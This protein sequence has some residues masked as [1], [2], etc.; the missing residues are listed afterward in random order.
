M[1]YFCLQFMSQTPNVLWLAGWY[2]TVLN[3]MSGDFIQR[4]ARA[5]SRHAPLHLIHVHALVDAVSVPE[6]TVQK[7]DALTENIFYFNAGKSNYF[8]KYLYFYSYYKAY[9]KI[10][11]HW[12]KLHGKP[13]VVHVHAPDRCG[14][15][16]VWVKRKYKSKLIFTEHWAIYNNVVNDNYKTR[17]LMFKNALKKLLRNAQKAVQVSHS[18][19]ADMETCTR[20]Q[21]PHEKIPNTVNTDLFNLNN[22][23]AENPFRFIHVS[24]M[25]ERKNIKGLLRTF[26]KLQMEYP[27][28]ELVLVGPLSVALKLW[29]QENELLEKIICMGELK[30]ENVAFEMSRAHAFVMY[31]HMENAPCVI[32][33]AHCCG[34]PVVS[35]RV[36]GIAEFVQE[37]ENGYLVNDGDDA[38]LFQKMKDCMQRDWNREKISGDAIAE[39]SYEVVGKKILDCYLN[40]PGL[41][42]D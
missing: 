20:I 41:C 8:Q 17:S 39:Y 29:M 35:S 11:S 24:S 19:H 10:I 27:E 14:L 1:G 3:P 2:P 25:D 21:L 30:Y 22:R 23:Q 15:L 42:A 4:H 5:Y 9:I 40:L 37:G 18:I 13:D 31:S 28:T 38:A 16:G 36:G 33:E 6:N 34:L 7:E 32:I 26:Q 12:V